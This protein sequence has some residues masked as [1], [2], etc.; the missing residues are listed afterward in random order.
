LGA[1]APLEV[2][3][4]SYTFLPE[5]SPGQTFVAYDPCRPIHYVV[6]EANSPDGG[7]QV[8]NERFAELSRVTG[9]V[10]IYDGP[11]QEGPD[12]ERKAF[13]PDVYGDRWAPIL[14]T[15]TSTEEYPT[16][17]SRETPEGTEYML[18]SAGS[19]MMARGDGRRVY[20]SGLV[21]LNAPALA[22][23]AAYDGSAVY[24]SVIAHE[25]AHLVGVGHVDDPTQ[26]MYPITDPQRVGYAAGDLTAL[27][28]LGQGPCVPEL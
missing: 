13:Q 9:M 16:L 25:L 24:S 22:K 21:T 28:K 11:T 7:L 8:I 3:S 18:G 26:L 1:P 27:T 14:I 17:A 2:I 15:W 5:G 12:D 19:N 6:R 4:D 10:F 23:A 20:V